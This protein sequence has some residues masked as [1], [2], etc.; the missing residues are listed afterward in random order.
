MKKIIIGIISLSLLMTMAVFGDELLA[1]FDLNTLGETA[2]ENSLSLEASQLTLDNKLLDQEEA[3][4]EAFNAN[5]MGG[6]RVTF[7][8]NRI[9]VESDTL[10]ADMEVLLAEMALEKESMDLKDT[11]YKKGMEYILLLDEK[12]LNQQLLENQNVY[13]ENIEKKVSNGI[14][15]STDLTNQAITYQNQELKVVELEGKLSGLKIEI[16]HL[17]GHPLDADLVIE[18]KLQKMLFT[19]FDVSNL[20]NNRYEKYPDI[21]R[22]TVELESKTIIFDLYA[23]KYKPV[24]KD[25]K[26]ALYNQQLAEIS[27]SDAKKNFEVSLR[28]AYNK[29]LNK[30]DAYLLAVKQ[31]ELQAK[32]YSDAQL[33]SDLGLVNDEDLLKAEE[34]KLQADYNVKLAIYDF[35]VSRIELQALY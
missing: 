25:Y 32:L 15:T 6:D 10:I 21:Y 12:A 33:R 24:D 31:A 27:L 7:I 17:L 19:S 23:S 29:Y 14:A 20:Y 3:E 8:K 18:D 30:N 1:A 13:Q 4:K 9:K 34:S 11:L 2:A 22:K 26:T 35:N 28:S 5:Q 16:N